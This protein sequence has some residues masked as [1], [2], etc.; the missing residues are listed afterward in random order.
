MNYKLFDDGALDAHIRRLSL[1]SPPSPPRRRPLSQGDS[2][3]GVFSEIGY[4]ESATDREEGVVAFFDPVPGFGFV[5]PA[6]S[7]PADKTANLYL[8]IHAL[9]RSGLLSI[10]KG[11]KIA[12]RREQS[13]HAGRKAEC[14]DIRLLDD[15]A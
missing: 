4:R 9:K 10:E 13:R 11:T 2:Q 1:T 14:Q 15:A 7:D 5:I 3:V 8:S 12:F 6:G